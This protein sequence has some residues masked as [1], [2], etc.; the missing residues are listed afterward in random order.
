LNY[1]VWHTAELQSDVKR[2]HQIV[3]TPALGLAIALETNPVFDKRNAERS[4][5]FRDCN[6][7][8]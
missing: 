4:S 3:A 1:F 7:R 8:H 5:A 6:Q 2:F